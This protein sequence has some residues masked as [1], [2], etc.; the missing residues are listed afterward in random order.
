VIATN[1]RTVVVVEGFFDTIAV[2][3][4]GYPVVGLMGS[5]LSPHQTG[6]LGRHFDRVLLMLD[7]D[8]AGRQGA[9]SI[10]QTLGVR[11]SVSA[12]SLDD[13]CQ[14]DQLTS[15]DIQ[16][17]VEHHALTPTVEAT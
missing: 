8:E 12:I 6:L 13:G 2:H 11:M 17:L 9:V 10:A 16:R 5:T 7:G 14:P 3:Q 4:A 1:A 15:P